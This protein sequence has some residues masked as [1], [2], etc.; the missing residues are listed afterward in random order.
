M[1]P[2]VAIKLAGWCSGKR[3]ASAP[4]LETDR[5]LEE[6]ADSDRLVYE[7]G[8]HMRQA[9]RTFAGGRNVSVRLGSLKEVFER[10]NVHFLD[11][12]AKKSDGSGRDLVTWWV[13]GV[14]AA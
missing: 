1:H 12:K 7:P 13:M 10:R 4:V 3:A 8:V 5:V 11:K 9:A 14:R 2:Q 6:L